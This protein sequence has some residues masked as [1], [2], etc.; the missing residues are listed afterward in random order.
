MNI[1]RALLTATALLAT[2]IGVAARDYDVFLGTFFGG[3]VLIFILVIMLK[4]GQEKEIETLRSKYKPYQ[5]KLL[6]GV[7]KPLERRRLIP[8]DKKSKG[9]PQ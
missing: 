1:W 4:W 9:T 7:A 5:I 8:M 6:Q 2:V 3:A